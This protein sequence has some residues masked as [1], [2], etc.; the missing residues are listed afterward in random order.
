MKSR[1]LALILV[2]SGA[3]ALAA[4]SYRVPTTP[5]LEA[6]ARFEMPYLS[7]NRIDNQ[8]VLS[9]ILPLDLAAGKSSLHEF[10]GTIGEN[11]GNTLRLSGAPGTATCI[12][13]EA[14]LTCDINYS[15]NYANS[16]ELEAYLGAKYHDQ[17]ELMQ[18][19]LNLAVSFQNDPFGVIE[20][21]LI[22]AP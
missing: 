1:I 12:R 5:D 2:L 4:N 22:P 9:Y 15:Q 19:I 10:T 16:Q 8:Y 17:P 14:Q 18:K 3:Q 20:M 7:F 13:A 21:T 11:T 6:F